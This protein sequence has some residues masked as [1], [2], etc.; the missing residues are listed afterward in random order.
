MP[1]QVGIH[2]LPVTPPQSRGW[3]A[4]ARHD[5]D[6]PA[7]RRAGIRAKT[8]ESFESIFESLDLLS[9]SFESLMKGWVSIA[10]RNYAECCAGNL[11]R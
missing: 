6:E 9:K 2:D 8:F 4:F 1:T 10:R 3:R 7:F 11:R 5:D